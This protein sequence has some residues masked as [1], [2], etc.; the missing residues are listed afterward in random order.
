LREPFIAQLKERGYI[1][2]IAYGDDIFL[3]QAD[4][5]IRFV[6]SEYQGIISIKT[7]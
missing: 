6:E 4:Y 1:L 2:D 3:R 5:R 7:E